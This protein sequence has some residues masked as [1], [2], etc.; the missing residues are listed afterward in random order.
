M[1]NLSVGLQRQRKPNPKSFGVGLCG[2][3]PT[4]LQFSSFPCSA[5]ECTLGGSSLLCFC[6]LPNR[7]SPV[8]DRSLAEFGPTCRWLQPDNPD[9]SPPKTK[10]AQPIVAAYLDS[11]TAL[12]KYAGATRR[13]PKPSGCFSRSTQQP[14][15]LEAGTLAPNT[16]SPPDEES[17]L[18]LPFHPTPSTLANS[19]RDS[20]LNQTA[21]LPHAIL[22]LS[23]VLVA[24]RTTIGRIILNSQPLFAEIACGIGLIRTCSDRSLKHN[25]SKQSGLA[26]STL[27][28]RPM[29]Q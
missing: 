17:R 26:A 12:K 20:G 5:W 1:D 2:L 3:N 18:L 10:V 4:D 6:Q 25:A 22:N 9:E 16:R 29:G 21:S 14:Q 8:L 7:K 27:F 28:W 15:L 23:K 19:S 11:V 13:S 24:E